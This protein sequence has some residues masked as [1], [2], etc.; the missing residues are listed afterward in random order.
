MICQH[1][2]YS[3]GKCPNMS[4]L[5][6]AQIFMTHDICWSLIVR[7]GCSLSLDIY[8]EL[9]DILWLCV[10]KATVYPTMH[11]E[12]ITY[13]KKAH[14]QYINTSQNRMM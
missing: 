2:S 14:I 4:S 8:E 10:H 9:L 13:N 11:C 3:P 5:G 6:T 12:M 7:S 1:I